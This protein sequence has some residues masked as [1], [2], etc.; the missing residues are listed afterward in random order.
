MPHGGQRIELCQR[1]STKTQALYALFANQKRDCRQVRYIDL[2]GARTV[3]RMTQTDPIKHHWGVNRLSAVIIVSGD[4]E[5]VLK[6]VSVDG[7][8]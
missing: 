6:T 3:A 1:Q 2:T 5:C 8:C 7:D 4:L